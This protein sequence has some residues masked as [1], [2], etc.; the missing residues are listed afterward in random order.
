MSAITWVMSRWRDR[1]RVEREPIFPT[2]EEKT[3]LITCRA[4]C[5]PQKG[6]RG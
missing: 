2:V 3:K 1:I 6:P 4:F 5:F